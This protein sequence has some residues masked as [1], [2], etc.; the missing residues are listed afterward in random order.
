MVKA[1]DTW[2]FESDNNFK[3]KVLE[4]ENDEECD[5]WNAENTLKLEEVVV[6]A[7]QQFKWQTTGADATLKGNSFAQWLKPRNLALRPLYWEKSAV[8]PTPASKHGMRANR[9]RH[10][11]ECA[12]L[13]TS[14][15]IE[16]A[17]HRGRDGA[18]SLPVFRTPSQHGPCTYSEKVSGESHVTQMSV[19]S[20]APQNGGFRP[21][22][23]AL[24]LLVRNIFSIVNQFQ[25][26]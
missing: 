13:K 22:V 10:V 11:F 14:A 17:V 15:K 2:D 8:M 16:K 6:S 20:H 7:R 25:L 9:E 1:A 24:T 4:H 21:N 18:S 26:T 12:D 5:D 19:E 23:N 3:F